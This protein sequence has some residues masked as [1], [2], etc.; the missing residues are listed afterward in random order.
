MHENDDEFHHPARLFKTFFFS[1]TLQVFC[2]NQPKCIRHTTKISF[3]FSHLSAGAKGE[4]LL[5]LSSSTTLLSCIYLSLPIRK[6]VLCLVKRRFCFSFFFFFFFPRVYVVVVVVIHLMVMTHAMSLYILAAFTVSTL[7]P[8]LFV[9]AGNL[10]LENNTSCRLKG[11]RK[12][13]ESAK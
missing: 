5:S 4:S 13:V 12:D 2:L 7:G 1:F 8:F 3:D 10:L 11:I 6:F 9:S